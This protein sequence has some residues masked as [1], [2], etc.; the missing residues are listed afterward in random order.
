MF[1]I[2][3]LELDGVFEIIPKRFGDGRGFFYSRFPE[4]AA[5]GTLWLQVR[6]VLGML[7]GVDAV[8]PIISGPA[9][10]RRGDA[11]QSVVLLGVDLPRYLR[12]IPLDDSMVEGALEVG[13]GNAVVGRQLATDLG[14]RTGGKLRLDAGDGRGTIVNVAGIFELGVRELDHRSVAA[15]V[16]RVPALAGADRRV[17]VPAVR[18]LARHDGRA[19]FG[20]ASSGFTVQ[21]GGVRDEPERRRG[22]LRLHLRESAARHTARRA[23]TGRGI[24]RAPVIAFPAA[25]PHVMAHGQPSRRCRDAAGCHAFGRR[26]G[27][28]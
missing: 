21:L 27:I 23:R 15:G 24:H 12:V 8:S 20:P 25:Q 13:S 9:F 16:R 5:G 18:P 6:D 28:P 2:K 10:G 19:R 7:R 22:L 11:V 14:L 3:R 1:E 17:R 4:P 26:C